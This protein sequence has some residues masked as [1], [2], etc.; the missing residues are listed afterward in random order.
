MEDKR[1]GEIVGE[2]LMI[3]VIIPVYN[4][5]TFLEECV[6]SV[7]EQPSKD[8]DIV[9][10]DD[11]STDSSGKICD[12][13]ASDNERVSVI[14]QKNGG[15]SAARNRGI[16]YF[17]DRDIVEE[18]YITFLD[19]D[20]VWLPDKMDSQFLHQL[21][22][23]V[24]ACPFYNATFSLERFSE[25]GMSLKEG[26]NYEPKSLTIWDTPIVVWSSFYKVSLLKKHNIR[27][28]KEVK[29]GEDVCFDNVA[30]YYAEN[31]KVI[32]HYYV[33]Y[34]NNR[35][36]LSHTMGRK[37][38]EPWMQVV[39]GL[40]KGLDEYGIEDEN[41]RQKTKEFCCWYLLEM[42]EVYY[43]SLSIWDEPYK[44][45]RNHVLGDMYFDNQM[46]LSQREKNRINLMI[47]HKKIFKVKFMTQGFIHH[48]IKLCCKM[49]FAYHYYEKRKY[50]L[51]KSQIIK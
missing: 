16:E 8:I 4:M 18:D 40:L 14:H 5:E 34:R 38:I 17:L 48:V 23:D 35:N 11:G 26:I 7:L 36:S 41:Y 12:S 22:G 25:R 10:I 30:L 47:E 2:Y 29:I 24:I 39:N 31:Y 37:R 6:Q 43:K 33:L 28:Q 50:P 27:F 19:A 32:N 20:D 46:S 51:L 15:L 49:P 9:L 1:D 13:L 45:I 21:S 42:S 44:I 3:H